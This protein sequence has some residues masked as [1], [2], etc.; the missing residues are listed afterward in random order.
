[1]TITP[2]ALLQAAGVCAAAVDATSIR[3]RPGGP[4]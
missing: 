1:M 4:S 2:N 3:H